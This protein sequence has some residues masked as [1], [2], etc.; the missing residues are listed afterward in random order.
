[1][2]SSG[3]FFTAA[4]TA[5]S[6]TLWSAALEAENASFAFDFPFSKNSSS[7]ERTPFTATLPK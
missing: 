4:V 5:S 6:T 2:P 1:L 7:A 3:V